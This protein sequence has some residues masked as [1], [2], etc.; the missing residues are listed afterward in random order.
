MGSDVRHVSPAMKHS[1]QKLQFTGSTDAK[2]ASS[3]TPQ[4]NT[5]MNA[6]RYIAAHVQGNSLN[7]ALLR[8]QWGKEGKTN[9]QPV[10]N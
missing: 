6:E 8:S 2:E 4:G 5:Q 3:M 7:W 1:Y 9:K 10:L